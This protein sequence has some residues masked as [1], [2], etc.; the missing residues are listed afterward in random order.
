VKA[1]AR[2]S[3]QSATGGWLVSMVA[4]G[5]MPVLSCIEHGR[6][7]VGS[8]AFAR[9]RRPRKHIHAN[10]KCLCFSL[11]Q[12]PGAS[13]SPNRRNGRDHTAGGPVLPFIYLMF[14]CLI[15]C[16]YFHRF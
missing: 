11:G 7:E 4:V 12:N 10:G 6:K 8:L 13:H 5:A 14:V 1:L 16:C 15:L 2:L 9:L 3:H